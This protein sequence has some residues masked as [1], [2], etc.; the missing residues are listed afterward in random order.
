MLLNIIPARNTFEGIIQSIPSTKAE[1]FK[2]WLAK[3]GYERL[4]EIENSEYNSLMNH[5]KIIN[6]CKYTQ[7]QKI[8]YTKFKY[9]FFAT[10]RVIFDK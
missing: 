10:S 2:H 9:I 8:V 6:K 1:P 4:E 5:C 7:T 3:V